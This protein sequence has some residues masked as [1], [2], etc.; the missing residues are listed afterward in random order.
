MTTCWSF[1]SYS[2]VI[3]N[4]DCQADTHMSL[5]FLYFTEMPF[6]FFIRKCIFTY[7]WY[8]LNQTMRIHRRLEPYW[9]FEPFLIVFVLPFELQRGFIGAKSNSASPQHS[10]SY[11]QA[12]A[13]SFNY[14]WPMV[15]SWEKSL[16]LYEWGFLLFFHN[17][18]QQQ[19]QYA[20][21]IEDSK[22][23]YKLSC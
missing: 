11:F 16:S 17:A 10:S 5:A 12:W 8:H 23:T 7:H 6:L 13:A 9:W 19:H 3:H 15:F 14:M 20:E 22:F 2:K 4:H 21:A 18:L 1:L